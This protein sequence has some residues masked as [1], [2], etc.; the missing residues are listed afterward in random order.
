MPLLSTTHTKA[1]VLDQKTVCARS[2]TTMRLLRVWCVQTV[3]DLLCTIAILN[4]ITESSV[5]P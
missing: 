1:L 2:N 3:N 4:K 5:T